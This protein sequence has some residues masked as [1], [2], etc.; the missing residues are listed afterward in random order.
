MVEIKT[1]Q[2]VQKSEMKTLSGSRLGMAILKA[3]EIDPE[4]VTSLT[5]ECEAGEFA[6][7]TI[8]RQIKDEHECQVVSQIVK[9]RV[10]SLE[11][12]TAVSEYLT[13]PSPTTLQ[14]LADS[15]DFPL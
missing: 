1:A 15:H 14:S 4:C 3:L 6:Q 8:R 12:T 9:Y 7:L 2:A 5:L 10:D 13:S 11:T